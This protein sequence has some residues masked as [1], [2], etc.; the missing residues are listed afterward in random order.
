MP[1]CVLFMIDCDYLRGSD[2]LLIKGIS[3][4]EHLQIR[5]CEL[6]LVPLSI[7]M[8][9]ALFKRSVVIDHDPLK[10]P[11]HVGTLY[12]TESALTVSVFRCKERWL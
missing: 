3:S 7:G 10:H 12:T 4:K 2:Y 8:S 6:V 11:F 5:G 9:C 1:T